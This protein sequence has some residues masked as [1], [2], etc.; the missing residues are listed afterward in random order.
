MEYYYE[1]TLFVHIIKEIT[2]SVWLYDIITNR[3][4]RLTR[5]YPHAIICLNYKGLE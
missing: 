5:I 3:V 2:D 4:V 1:L